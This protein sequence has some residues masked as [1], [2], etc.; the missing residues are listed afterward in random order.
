MIHGVLNVYK[1]KGYTSHDVVAK[2]RGIV[3]QKRSGIPEPLI[4]MPKEYFRSALGKQQ[5]FVTC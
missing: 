2:L 4:R 1:E 5:S 3:K